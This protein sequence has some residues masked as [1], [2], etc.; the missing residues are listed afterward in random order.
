MTECQK[1]HADLLLAIE[2]VIASANT[3][4]EPAFVDMWLFAA[5]HRDYE[6]Y[7]NAPPMPMVD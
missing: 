5:M 2:R 3:D 6:R 7:L 1:A 4:S